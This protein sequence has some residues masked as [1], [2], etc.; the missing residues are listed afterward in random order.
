M[1]SEF[2]DWTIFIKIDEVSTFIGYNNEHCTL[3]VVL[4]ISTQEV[5]I[6]LF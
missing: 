2:C 3:I 4:I 5:F 1:L 6:N